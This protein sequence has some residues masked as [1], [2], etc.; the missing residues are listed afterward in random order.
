[1][2][3]RINIGRLATLITTV[4]LLAGAHGALA[5]DQDLIATT[6]PATSCQPATHAQAALVGLS[7]AAWVFTGANTGSVNFYCPLPVNRFTKSDA[8]DDNDIL[9]FRVYYRDTDGMADD[10]EVEARLAL[11]AT[12]LIL[13]GTA[14]TSNDSNETNDTMG[15]RAVSHDVN[16]AAMYSFIVTMRRDNASEDPAFTGIDFALEPVP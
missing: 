10:A 3:A 2:F 11:R 16:T 7:N 12:S 13:L 9:G 14:F 4:A 15:Y 5:N 1:M 8:T 6:V